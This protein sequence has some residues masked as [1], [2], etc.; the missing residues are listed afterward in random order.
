MG[1]PFFRYTYLASWPPISKMV[2]T[3]PQWKAVPAAWAMI[4]LY[5]PGVSRKT[6]RISREEP[7]V[8]ARGMRTGRSPTCRPISSRQTFRAATGSPWVRP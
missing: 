7:V 4:S 1:T 5:T 3:S 6:P 8:A 2:S